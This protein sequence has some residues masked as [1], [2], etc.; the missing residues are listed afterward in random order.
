LSQHSNATEE[1]AMCLRIH[2]LIAGS[3]NHWVSICCTLPEVMQSDGQ[4]QTK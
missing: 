2:R 3:L 1:Y 4:L